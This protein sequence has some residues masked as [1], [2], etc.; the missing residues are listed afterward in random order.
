MFVF[1]MPFNFCFTLFEQ[2]AKT[3]VTRCLV[4][5]PGITYKYLGMI[6]FGTIGFLSLDILA[7]V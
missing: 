5:E 1:S 4:G 7:L 2:V 3:F 6:V